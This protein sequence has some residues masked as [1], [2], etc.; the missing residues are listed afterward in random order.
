MGC[1][2]TQYRL[3]A[4]TVAPTGRV[5]CSVLCVCLCARAR[6]VLKFVSQCQSVNT[7]ALPRSA[8]CHC[9]C[10]LLL[11]ARGGSVR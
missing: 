6:S 11:G 2:C 9:Q 3:R 5:T 7:C 4:A 8:L 10:V 1:V